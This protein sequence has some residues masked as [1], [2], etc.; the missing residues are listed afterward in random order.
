MTCVQLAVL[1]IVLLR[2]GL[3]A[4]IAFAF[5]FPVGLMMP[6][7]SDWSAWYGA[8]ATI[9]LLTVGALALYG[10]I[11]SMAGRPLFTDAMIEGS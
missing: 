5:A 2:Y 1:W 9:G 4:R 6:G 10:F 11:V 7:A 8:P 3:L